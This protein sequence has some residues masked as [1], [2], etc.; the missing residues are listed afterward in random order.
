VTGASAGPSIGD[1]RSSQSGIVRSYRWRPQNQEFA[2]LGLIL[3]V[4]IYARRGREAGYRSA[5][6]RC[7]A[8]KSFLL[9]WE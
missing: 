2:L 1:L 4:Q 3:G 8:A 5:Y 9:L 6:L 7:L